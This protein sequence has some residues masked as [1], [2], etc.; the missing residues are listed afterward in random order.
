MEGK[1]KI[2][3]LRKSWIDEGEEDLKTMEIRISYTVARDRQE[4]RNI[5][6]EANT[7]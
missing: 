2:G 5:L 3:R 6:L 4:W 7:L 1:S